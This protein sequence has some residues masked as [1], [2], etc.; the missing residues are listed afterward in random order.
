[1]KKKSEIL[2]ALGECVQSNR[3]FNMTIGKGQL[4]EIKCSYIDWSFIKLFGNLIVDI[5]PEDNE[6]IRLVLSKNEIEWD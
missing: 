2:N 3:V 4:W 1:M 5:T 6:N